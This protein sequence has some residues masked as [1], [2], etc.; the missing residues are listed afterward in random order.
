MIGKSLSEL[1]LR[2]RQLL[3]F[4]LCLG[5]IA[6]ITACENPGTT[7]HARK[8]AILQD[9]PQEWADALKTGFIEE[10]QAQGFKLGE[11]ITVI[12]RAAAG[13]PQALTTIADSFA[14]GDYT[15]I[16]SLGTQSTQEIFSRTKTKPIIFGA[17]TD[18]VKAGFFNRN[19]KQPL[20]NITGTQDLWPYPAQFDLIKTLLPNVKKIGIVYNSS[21]VNSQVSVE[22]IKAE[23][24]KRGIQL[25]ER[26]ITSE[27]EVQLAISALLNQNIDLFFVPADNTAQTSAPTII[28]LCQQ[29]KVPVFTGIS[30]IV[31]LGALATVG[32]NYTELGKVNARQAAEI[33]RGKQARDVPVSIAD[34]GDIYINLKAAR[35]LGISVPDEIVKKSFKVI[36]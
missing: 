3:L 4:P 11:E 22:Y 32:T 12:P 5:I 23:C 14:K 24:Q 18:P 34:K 15:L 25:E 21:E 1:N 13:D 36:Q 29:K 30:G 2:L 20:G 8:V 27:S 17:V 16:Y 35:S 19:L 31:E 9:K 33:L 26:T 7:S 10:L 28:A 6:V